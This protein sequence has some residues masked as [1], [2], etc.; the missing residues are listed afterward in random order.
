MDS[1]AAQRE[2]LLILCGGLSRRMGSPKPL[3]TYRG[4]PL[5]ERLAAAAQRPL[6]LAAAG[7]RFP[8]LP[9]AHYLSDALPERQGA[10]S[11]VLPALEWAAGQGY[12][13]VYVLSCDTLLLPE[14]VADCLQQARN[15]AA[16][17][18]GV[19]ALQ[20]GERVY[21]LLAHWSAALV[22]PL[23]QYLE[24]GQRRVT[25]WL[26]T[27][28]FAA[29]PLSAEWRP[30]CNFNTPQEFEQAVVQAERLEWE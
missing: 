13:G 22:E 25:T 17:Y 3:L 7:Q 15:N 28:P 4:V 8:R 11:A 16:W 21:P 30:L 23:R 5:I 20:D 10:L 2:P 27:V 29:A 1:T 24:S 18:G 14:Q 19:A 26:E 6:W 12:G 9:Q